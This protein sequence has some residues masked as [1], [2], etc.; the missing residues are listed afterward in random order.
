MKNFS[1]KLSAFIL[2]SMSFMFYVLIWY[3]YYPKRPFEFLSQ[4]AVSAVNYRYVYT[5]RAGTSRLQEM[6]E[7]DQ[8]E[9]ISALQDLSISS[10]VPELHPSELPYLTYRGYTETGFIQIVLEN[11]EYIYYDICTIPGNT[12]YYERFWGRYILAVARHHPDFEDVETSV[13][14]ARTDYLIMNTLQ[15]RKAIETLRRIRIQYGEEYGR[16]PDSNCGL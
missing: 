15:S 10:P 16:A 13:N 9:V 7:E 3:K 12:K 6:T 1:I 14:A 8:K 11:G 2:A 4:S 5:K